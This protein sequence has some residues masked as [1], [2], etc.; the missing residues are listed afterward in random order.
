[1]LRQA[2][3]D[4]LDNAVLPEAVVEAE[5]AVVAAPAFT[6][7]ELAL[8]LA[9]AARV[10]VAAASTLSWGLTEAEAFDDA[11]EPLAA[12]VGLVVTSP[13]VKPGSE[14]FRSLG[15]A[16]GAGLAVSPLPSSTN[17]IGAAAASTT[18]IRIARRRPDLLCP[19]SAGGVGPEGVAAGMGSF[20]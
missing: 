2:P 15:I 7:D 5:D 1:M 9:A 4:A 13:P 17:T 16:A 19:S 14:R 11:L 6:G 20:E 3:L 10:V 8:T 18:P 12:T